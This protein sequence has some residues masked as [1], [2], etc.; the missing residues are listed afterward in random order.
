MRAWASTRKLVRRAGRAVRAEGA[1]GC[2]RRVQPARGVPTSGRAPGK[3]FERV[4]ARQV[5]E[6]KYGDLAGNERRGA[7]EAGRARDGRHSSWLRRRW[8]RDGEGAQDRGLAGNRRRAGPEL[9]VGDVERRARTMVRRRAIRRRTPLRRFRPRHNARAAGPSAP[10]QRHRQ[11]HSA[12]N[13][14]DPPLPIGQRC[15]C[16]VSSTTVRRTR[17]RC[18]SRR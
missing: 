15:V 12:H 5:V 7:F 11:V 17:A 13:A 6:L 9:A 16:F 10:A 4:C 1:R 14:R 2:G 3:R 8:A 18:L